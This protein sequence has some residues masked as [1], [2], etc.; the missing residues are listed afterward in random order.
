MYYPKQLQIIKGFVFTQEYMGHTQ[1]DT[2]KTQENHGIVI[3]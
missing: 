1:L 3:N 2:W